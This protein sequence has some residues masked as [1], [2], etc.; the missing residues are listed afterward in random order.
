MELNTL[1]QGDDL[2]QAFSLERQGLTAARALPATC[3]AQPIKICA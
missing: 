1:F 2:Q 3:W